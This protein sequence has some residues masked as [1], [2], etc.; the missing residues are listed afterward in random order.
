MKIMYCRKDFSSMTSTTILDKFIPPPH[1]SSPPNQ[2]LENGAFWL[3][4]GFILDLGRGRGGWKFAVPFFSAQDCSPLSSR[5]HCLA[6]E[7][8]WENGAWFLSPKNFSSVRVSSPKNS[9]WP[10]WGENQLTMGNY[11]F[12]QMFEN[13]KR[14]RQARNFTTNVPK[15]L[16]ISNRL[17]NR[18]F[19][20]IDVGCPWLRYPFW[21]KPLTFSVLGLLTVRL[22]VSKGDAYGELRQGR[23]IVSAMQTHL[24]KS[25][26]N[27]HGSM[28]MC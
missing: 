4:P 23:N 8:S 15:I 3:L 19:P 24:L 20:K 22:T 26:I 16:W 10:F 2:W 17:P 7:N 13:L 6:F 5:H 27:W 9:R 12:F 14:G 21:S 28:I 25:S 18:Y 1:P 11:T